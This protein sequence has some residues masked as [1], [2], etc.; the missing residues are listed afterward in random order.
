MHNSF[1][2]RYS[3]KVAI[4]AN[5]PSLKEVLPKLQ[6]DK[7]SDTD[8]IVLNFFG[9]EAV[10]TR[11]KPKHYCLADPMFFHPNHKQKEVRNLF[12]V[13]NRNVDWDMNIYTPIG[14]VDDFKV[15]SAL[16]NPHIRL[17]SLNTITYKGFECLRHFFYKHGLSMPLAQT[18]AN[19]VIYVGTNS[20]YQQIGL[21]GVDHTFFDSMCVDGNNRLCNKKT[22]FYDNG[23]VLLK[24]ILKSDNFQIW[25]VGDYVTAIG[26]MFL[27]FIYGLLSFEGDDQKTI[28]FAVAASC[29]KHTIKGDYNQVSK[30]EVLALMMGD[31]SGRVKRLE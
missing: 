24:P 2:R 5:G 19:M 13:L 31:A 21:Y 3:G 30:E 6:M 4:L 18:V 25:M 1:S 11:I 17:V 16:S 28:D 10:F 22:Y 8:F 9:M 29:L 7:F 20:G 15:F 23:E 14:S 12:S 27:A 26:R